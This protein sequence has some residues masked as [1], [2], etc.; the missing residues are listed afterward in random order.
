MHS[1][2][3]KHLC[4]CFIFSAKGTQSRIPYISLSGKSAMNLIKLTCTASSVPILPAFHHFQEHNSSLY[5]LVSVY[6]L[7][8]TTLHYFPCKLSLQGMLSNQL[9]SVQLFFKLV[10]GKRGSVWDA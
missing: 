8:F 7:A 5:R 1:A 9:F 10:Y 3:F 2:Y 6:F 4:L